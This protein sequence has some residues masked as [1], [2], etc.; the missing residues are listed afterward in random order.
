MV[1]NISITNELF[2][3]DFQIFSGQE[4]GQLS[5]K[6]KLPFAISFGLIKDIGNNNSRLYFTT[7]FYGRIKEYK[8]VDA[9]INDDIAPGF[10]YE[11]LENK[12]WLS[13]A[14][15]TRSFMN[16]VIGYSWKL[17]REMEFYNSIRSDLS[18]IK[19]AEFDSYNNYNKLKT[20]NYNIYHYSAG[21]KFNIKRNSF[22]AGG[23]V[24]FGYNNSVKQVANFS[25]PIELNTE[26]N[27]VL[28]GRIADDMTVMYWAFNIYIGATLNF[29]KNDN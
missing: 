2:V 11:R 5:T 21:L 29:I 13:F 19:N 24:S 27:L 1:S 9:Q 4:K 7:E 20:S 15:A 17:K 18:S 23:Q 12:D 6:F 26:D 22:I 16:I 8:L 28:Q 3:P 14:M 10:I 25:D